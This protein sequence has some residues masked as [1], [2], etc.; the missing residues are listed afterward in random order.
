[1]AKEKVNNET[2]VFEEKQPTMSR[3]IALS[4]DGK[5][6]IIRT[7]RTDIVHVNYVHKILDKGVTG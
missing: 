5:W 3:N 6:L 2:K 1:M 4:N 7:L